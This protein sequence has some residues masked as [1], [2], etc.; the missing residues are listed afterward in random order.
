[1]INEQLF[2]RENLKEY[3]PKKIPTDNV[4]RL[5]LSENLYGP[6]PKVLHIVN[7]ESR[8]IN[9]YPENS[10]DNLVRLLSEKMDI[11]KSMI[12]LGN[13]SDELIFLSILSCVQP[14]EIGITSMHTF[15][16]F[17][18][19]VAN[20][21]GTCVEIPLKD[22]CVDIQGI[23]NS[24]E[25]YISEGKKVSV[26]YLCNPH[27]PTGTI[28]SEKEIENLIHF[29][30]QNNIFL[31]VDEAYIEYA[32][33]EG[34]VSV[35]KYIREYPKI[36]I[37]RTFSK[38]YALAGLRCGYMFGN[39]DIIHKIKIY[40]NNLVFHVNRLAHIAAYHSLKDTAYFDNI[41]RLNK[42]NKRFLEESLEKLHIKFIPSKT[43][44]VLMEIGQNHKELCEYLKNSHG[45]LVSD[46][47]Q[48]GLNGYVRVGVGKNSD[49]E[50]FISGIK[51]YYSM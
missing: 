38:F 29:T 33:Y 51:S 15:A 26:I 28:V 43:N 20:A 19:A 49:I 44:F 23:I 34:A 41:L 24:A 25:A 2:R 12:I 37:L 10:Y 31:L 11:D 50:K 21:G 45:I 27:N 7:D 35:E 32:M 3:E 39:K 17:K 8:K 48:L 1:M 22:Y 30:Y 6:S 46:C 13:G 40:R 14:G 4:I 42:I 47:E 16:G 36:G 9:F 18:C 5:S